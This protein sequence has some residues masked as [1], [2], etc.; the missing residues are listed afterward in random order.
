[1]QVSIDHRV[2]ASEADADGMHEYIY[3]YDEFSFTRNGTTVCARSYRDEPHVATL[4]SITESSRAA[5]PLTAN[6]LEPTN[7]S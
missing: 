6:D 3:S 2:D 5:R 1:M 7:R 4:Q